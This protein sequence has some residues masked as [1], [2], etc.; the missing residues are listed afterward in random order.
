MLHDGKSIEPKKLGGKQQLRF[1]KI[2]ISYHV[3][4]HA[5]GRHGVLEAIFE[6]V[7]GNS[8]RQSVLHF[9]SRGPEPGGENRGGT[10]SFT[11]RPS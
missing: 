11:R 4:A 5:C 1:V 10:A 9:Y 2:A 6:G 7:H 8:D 3:N